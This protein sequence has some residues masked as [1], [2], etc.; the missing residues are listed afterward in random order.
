M[1]I[2]LDEISRHN[3]SWDLARQLSHRHLNNASMSWRLVRNGW[4][5]ALNERE[6]L[7]LFNFTR[8]SPSCLLKAA[9]IPQRT[10]SA[11]VVQ[12]AI[13]SLGV[14]MACV[15]VAVFNSCTCTLGRR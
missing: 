9:N 3:R 5:G 10:A 13:Q 6:F 11:E 4:L 2:N 1:M 7:K 15:V 14:P 8:L 12:Q